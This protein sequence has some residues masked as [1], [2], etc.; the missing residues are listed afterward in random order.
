MGTA[1]RLIVV[2]VLLGQLSFGQKAAT[3]LDVKVKEFDAYILK[4]QKEWEVPGLAVAVV[5]DGNVILSKGYG[6]KELGTTDRVDSKTL[7]QCASTTKAMTAVCMGMLV[8]EGRVM[9][10]D[11]VIKHLPEFQLYDPFVTREITIRDLFIHD[12]GLGNADFLWLLMDIPPDEML[13]KMRDVKP[14]YS[15]RS[16]WIYQNIFYVA[17]GKVIEKVSG[18]PWNIFVNERLFKPLGM[19]RTFP[20]TKEASEENRTKPH[21]RIEGVI[22]VIKHTNADAVSSAGSV[23]SSIDDMAKWASVM[24]DSSK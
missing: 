23:W 10:S 8:D 19:L 15:L 17:A 18:K 6:I 12:T 13:R 21:D 11:P 22:T 16:G 7:F 3:P 24:I 20:T 4:A 1:S 14:T 9:W 5:K 2:L